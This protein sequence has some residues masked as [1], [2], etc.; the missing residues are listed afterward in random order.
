MRPPT[1]A[2][3][4]ARDWD[5]T[6]VGGGVVGRRDG[7]EGEG[8]GRGGG[9]GDG[10]ADG[11]VVA[12]VG[13]EVEGRRP[14]L[15]QRLLRRGRS[16][17]REEWEGRLDCEYAVVEGEAHDRDQDGDDARLHHGLELHYGLD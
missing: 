14:L 11:G 10:L 1:W 9:G 5:G 4:G 6:W 16:V 17:D 8:A 2:T 15:L 3:G 13:G 12:A 7:G